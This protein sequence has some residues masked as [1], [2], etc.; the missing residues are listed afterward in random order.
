MNSLKLEFGA[1]Q[2]VTNVNY[3]LSKAN[4]LPASQTSKPDMSGLTT[5]STGVDLG[6]PCPI[7]VYT[8]HSTLYILR[9]EGELGFHMNFSAQP[10]IYSYQC[11]YIGKL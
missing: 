6:S 2:L 7:T 9:A 11:P 3:P 8:V 4:E 5:I 10:H 1:E